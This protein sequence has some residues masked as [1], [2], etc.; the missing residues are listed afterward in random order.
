MKP[1]RK[2]PPK[3]FRSAQ[4]YKA[5]FSSPNEAPADATKLYRLGW[6]TVDAVVAKHTT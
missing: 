2:R 1:A 5:Y 3:H 4:E 6:T